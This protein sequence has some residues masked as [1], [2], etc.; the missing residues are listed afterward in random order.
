MIF[1]I[2]DEQHRQAPKAG[3]EGEG[4]I[5]VW[6]NHRILLAALYN[7]NVTRA[8]VLANLLQYHFLT[9]TRELLTS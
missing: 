7:S 4:F 6:D 1:E 3:S 2:R 5:C 8:T 9:G